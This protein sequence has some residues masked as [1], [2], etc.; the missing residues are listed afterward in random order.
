MFHPVERY[1]SA[2]KHITIVYPALT[3]L[4]D[5]WAKLTENIQKIQDTR[6]YKVATTMKSNS[7]LSAPKIL[8]LTLMDKN[9][10]LKTPK[11]RN[12]HLT[13]IYWGL[14]SIDDSSRWK[15]SGVLHM[16]T[17]WRRD[18]Q[19]DIKADFAERGTNL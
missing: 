9:G 11:D 7:A 15:E 17:P 8:Q 10:L 3:Y 1:S 12:K 13:S 4:S 6:R 2:L 18:P 5:P 14:H 16:E 19:G